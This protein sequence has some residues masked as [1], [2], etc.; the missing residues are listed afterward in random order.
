MP[1]ITHVYRG[2]RERH[3]PYPPIARVLRPGDE[4]DLDPDEV[5][6]D[7]PLRPKAAPRARKTAATRKPRTTAAKRAPRD[8]AAASPEPTE[9]ETQA[10]GAAS[11]ATSA[12]P[13][14]DIPASD[15]A[16]DPSPPTAASS[17]RPTRAQKTE[18]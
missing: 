5:P 3:Y 15:E 16:A 9:P 7:V 4:I 13:D 12:E 18:G 10:D 11:S 2:D 17:R 8:A 14:A 6:T 1:K